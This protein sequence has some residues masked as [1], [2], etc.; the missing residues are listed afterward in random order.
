MGWL[1]FSSFLLVITITSW[2]WSMSLFPMN[3]VYYGVYKGVV[4]QAVIPYGESGERIR[5]YFDETEFE[6]R[7]GEYFKE[8]ASRYC[9]DFSLSYAYSDYVSA[10]KWPHVASFTL[11]ASLYGGLKFHRAAT[12]T[13]RRNEA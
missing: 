8:N 9:R 3:R 2:S 12:F 7:V 11:D 5:P 1:L 4:E 10:G 6:Y 13:I